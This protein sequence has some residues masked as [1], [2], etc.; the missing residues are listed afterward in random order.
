MLTGRK[1]ALTL[2]FTALVALALGAGCRGFFPKPKLTAV[3]IT[4]AN[5]TIT[6]I[7]PNNT[8]QFSAVGT[9]DDGNSGSTPVTWSSSPTTV[10]NID[11]NSGIATAAGVGTATITA[12][13]TILPTISG[14][15]QL[16]VVPGNVTSI[17]V[18]PS[19]VDT[20]TNATFHLLAKDQSGNDISGSVTWTFDQQGT[21]TQESGF[22]EGPPDS[23]G[24]LFTV[25]TLTPTVTFPATFD[26]VATLTVNGT[27]VTSNKIT[28]TVTS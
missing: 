7:A 1:L 20:Q 18:T 9:F 23:Q 27:T 13:S 19:H 14:T 28:V 24:Q 21:T 8:K 3:G 17:T 10:A 26:V 5:Q 4:P 11:T 22:A 25:G 15:T 16:T 6:D 2:A 12:T